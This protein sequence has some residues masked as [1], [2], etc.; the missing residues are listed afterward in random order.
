METADVTTQAY[1]LNSSKTS[2]TQC[3][4]NIQVVESEFFELILQWM[5]GTQDRIRITRFWMWTVFPV[6]KIIQKCFTQF[7]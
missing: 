6:K 3:A 2:N 4:N 5:L 7:A 1:Q